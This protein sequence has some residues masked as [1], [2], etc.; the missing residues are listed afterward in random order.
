VLDPGGGSSHNLIRSKEKGAEGLR[1]R[2]KKMTKTTTKT[3]TTY[4]YIIVRID[5]Y[6]E[7]SEVLSRVVASSASEALTMSGYTPDNACDCYCCLD[8]A[9][10]GAEPRNEY[11]SPWFPHVAAY[12]TD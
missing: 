8:Y 2:E 1:E 12:V 7:D 4:T 6:P 9:S 5:L 11:G 3:T 10:A